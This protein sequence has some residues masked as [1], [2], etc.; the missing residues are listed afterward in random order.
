MFIFCTITEMG[1]TFKCGCSA[2]ETEMHGTTA[3]FH[4]I[5]TLWVHV[6]QNW[7]RTFFVWTAFHHGTSHSLRCFREGRLALFVVAVF[8]AMIRSFAKYAKGDFAV[9][10]RNCL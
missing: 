4:T 3:A 1:V 6:L 2:D 10:A 7:R 9:N 8:P 5:A